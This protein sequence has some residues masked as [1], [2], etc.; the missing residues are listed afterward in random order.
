LGSTIASPGSKIDRPAVIVGGSTGGLDGL[1]PASPVASDG[2]ASF[3]GRS[4]DDV[5]A[6]LQVTDYD[7]HDIVALRSRDRGAQTRLVAL[8]R[9][10]GFTALT[11]TVVG[12]IDDE[13]VRGTGGQVDDRAL[14]P[15]LS[16][17]SSG[18]SPF[19][20]TDLFIYGVLGAAAVMGLALALG[21]IRQL[22]K[23]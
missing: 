3:F 22:L 12:L 18:P 10:P 6:V 23:R 11:G 5:A 13:L 9:E 4:S 14:L 1:G 20:T 15:P 7:G 19:S 16:D 2:L 17:Q 21:P 8:A